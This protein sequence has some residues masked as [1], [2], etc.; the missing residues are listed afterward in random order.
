MKVMTNEVT[1]KPML[2]IRIVDRST[3]TVRNNV[4]SLSKRE[5]SMELVLVVSSNHPI[6]FL[7]IAATKY[8]TEFKKN[9]KQKRKKEYSQDIPNKA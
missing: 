8:D 1:V 6:S 9:K 2:T 3:T 5:A 7:K 4:A